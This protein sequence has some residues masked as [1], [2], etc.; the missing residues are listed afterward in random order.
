MRELPK[1]RESYIHLG[2]DFTAQGHH[3]EA[4]RSGGA[5]AAARYGDTRLDFAKWL[6]DRRNPL[7]ARVTVNRMWQ[8]Y[9]GKGI[10]ETENDFG[11]QGIEAHASRT[12]GLSGQR[13]RAPEVEPE[14]DPPADCDVRGVPA[15]FEAA[16]GT[17]RERTP[18]TSCWRGRTGCGWKPRLF[19]IPAL[20]AS[21]LLTDKVGG[22]SVYP[23][24][25]DGAM[26]VT[27]VSG[28]WPTATGPDRYRRGFTR[29]SVARLP[30]PGLVVFDAPD[31]TSTCTRRVR[32][33]TPLQAL[34]AA[35]RRGVHGVCGRVWRR[36]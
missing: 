16:A 19:A 17:G 28:A 27:Q 22:P 15:V 13:V 14:G 7:T 8:E 36:A 10:V 35:E 20:S 21:G 5:A 29:S 30:F 26:S 31:A 34:D 24:I 12:A 33:N 25:P 4:G 32:S 6:V 3:G 9:F 23:P 2:G 11:P 1:P 18:T